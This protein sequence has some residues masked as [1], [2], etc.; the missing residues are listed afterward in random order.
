MG[1]LYN[2]IKLRLR[3]SA[4][5]L[6]Q[7]SDPKGNGV[8][9]VLVRNRASLWAILV[10]SSLVFALLSWIGYDIYKKLLFCILKQMA[11]SP[12]HV[13][14]RA[15]QAY[16]ATIGVTG[17]LQLWFSLTCFLCQ[18]AFLVETTLLLTFT[19]SQT[20]LTY[21][22]GCSTIKMLVA[23]LGSGIPSGN[24]GRW[25][26]LSK[27]SHAQIVRLRTVVEKPVILVHAV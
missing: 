2:E 27:L 3:N 4:L 18:L 7:G 11:S 19:T 13:V 21:I 22:C 16:L 23:R 8:L 1:L 26:S 9:A 15:N 24:T 10:T 17:H 14:W 20:S 6:V 25:I 12:I 5:L